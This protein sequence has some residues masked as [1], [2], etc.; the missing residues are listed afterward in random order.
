MNNF[1]TGFTKHAAVSMKGIKSGMNS[2]HLNSPK[3]MITTLS[4]FT[5]N[6]ATPLQKGPASNNLSATAHINTST[7]SSIPKPK[8]PDLST[9]K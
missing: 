7:M 9:I 3:S 8:S 1:W 4:K 2:M 5:P 6:K